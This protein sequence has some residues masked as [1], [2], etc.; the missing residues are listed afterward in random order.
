MT[1]YSFSHFSDKGP[2][3][4]NQDSL[5]IESRVDHIYACIADGVGGAAAGGDASKLATKFFVDE[6]AKESNSTMGLVSLIQEIN[7][8]LMNLNKDG[9][10]TTF[11]GVS[12]AG[13]RLHGVHVGDTRV[14]VLR[15]NGISQLTIDHTELH[16][17]VSEGKLSFEDAVT[18]PRKHVLESA[19]GVQLKSRIDTFEFLLL[20]GDRVLLTTDGVHDALSKLNLR[21]ISKQS[22][23]IERYLE[24][25][26][27]A[28]DSTGATDNF[29]AIG[30]EILQ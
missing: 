24:N 21:D 20:P 7:N 4:E 18:Y 26:K 22:D 27:N 13:N 5:A 17:L 23:S 14:Y 3:P 11:S 6:L 28:I 2:Y 30:I 9:V 15:G 19:L 8:S 29:S 16:R 12:I 1:T 25:I 10:F